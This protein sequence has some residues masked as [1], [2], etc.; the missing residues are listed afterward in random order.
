MGAVVLQ[1]FSNNSRYTEALKCHAVECLVCF[2]GCASSC[3]TTN[4]SV[5][6]WMASQTGSLP[7]NSIASLTI[8]LTPVFLL[9]SLKDCIDKK[10][11]QWN[12]EEDT[13]YY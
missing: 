10:E 2:V 8:K 12:D 11:T 13:D 7:P 1:S 5:F 9:G 4:C 6:M 3:A